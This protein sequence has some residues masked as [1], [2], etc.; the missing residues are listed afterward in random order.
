[1]RESPQTL[2]NVFT[3]ILVIP[4]PPWN[5]DTEQ[6]A[7]TLD[8]HLGPIPAELVQARANNVAFI[9]LVLLGN[10]GPLANGQHP[11]VWLTQAARDLGLPLIPVVSP[12]R[13]PAYRAAVAAVVAR[14]GLGACLRLTVAEWPVNAQPAIDQLMN[15]IGVGRDQVDLVFD[16]EDEAGAMAFTALTQ[17]LAALPNPE[18]WKSLIIA[19]TAM[20]Q[21]LPPGAGLR[22]VPREEW[23]G[24][25]ALVAQLPAGV[26]RPTFGD[27]GVAHPDPQM[28]LDP[29]VISL[30][31]ALRYTAGDDWLIAKGALYK[32][33]GGQGIGGA[34]TIGAAQLLRA[35]A[36]YTPGHCPFEVWIDAVCAGGPGGTPSSWR[37]YG[38]RHHLAVVADQVAN[39]PG[40]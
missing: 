14:D 32:G 24:H 35:N 22:V 15:D 13:T 7:E 36:A 6:P 21:L 29:R 26:R 5:F 37:R 30:S 40:P 2:H 16:L 28:D 31:A 18:E 8:Q 25:R 1:M 9:D 3:P 19:G 12:T 33:R 20:P 11:L 17:Q 34:A 4:P 27:Y 38:T 23:I 10:D 39:L